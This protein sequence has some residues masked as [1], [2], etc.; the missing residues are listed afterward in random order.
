MDPENWHTFSMSPFQAVD[1]FF[2]L[3]ATCVFFV[4]FVDILGLTRSKLSA[5]KEKSS[6]AWQG[7]ILV[8]H[9]CEQAGS[10]YKKRRG[11]LERAF[12]RRPSGV[13]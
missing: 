3:F 2:F 9:L 7:L 13:V 12:Y 8:A 1:V 11:L 10:I 5:E 4:F 6:T